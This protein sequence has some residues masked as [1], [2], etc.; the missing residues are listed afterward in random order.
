MH[1]FPA[2]GID[3]MSTMQSDFS[4]IPMQRFPAKSLHRNMP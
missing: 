4:I 1:R 2:I 3:A